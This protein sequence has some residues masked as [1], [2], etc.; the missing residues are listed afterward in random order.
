MWCRD[1]RTLSKTQNLFTTFP[2]CHLS[3][4]FPHPPG[5][6]AHWTFATAPQISLSLSFSV[7]GQTA[8]YGW[9]QP[10]CPAL[11][12]LLG[13]ASRRSKCT[14]EEVRVWFLTSSH[15]RLRFLWD[16]VPLPLLLVWAPID[17][18]LQ[19]LWS[20]LSTCSD[21]HSLCIFRAQ[22]WSWLP[23]I[24]CKPWGAHYSSVFLFTL[25]RELIKL[26]VTTVAGATSILPKPWCLTS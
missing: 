12:F 16:W 19:K 17:T 25:P 24:N 5:L 1:I 20:Q 3:M 2:L 26:S 15:F 4:S 8:F 21:D 11:R 7:P 9:C 10:D 14:E 18:T 6:S 23:A 22:W 13:N